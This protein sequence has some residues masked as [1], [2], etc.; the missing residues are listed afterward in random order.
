MEFV[1]M[2]D[3]TFMAHKPTGLAVCRELIQRDTGVRWSRDERPE[4]LGVRLA[5]RD[6]RLGAALD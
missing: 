4:V 1:C 5:R 2:G 3:L 6:G